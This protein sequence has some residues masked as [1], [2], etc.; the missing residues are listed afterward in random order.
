MRAW[1]GGRATSLKTHLSLVWCSGKL[2]KNPVEF[3]LLIQISNFK[4]IL[5]ASISNGNGG[6]KIYFSS[7]LIL[8]FI[9]W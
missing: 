9:V 3:Y 5:C 7:H 2:F 1:G 4:R 8:K 6:L